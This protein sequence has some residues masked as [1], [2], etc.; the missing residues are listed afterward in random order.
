MSLCNHCFR[1]Q[2]VCGDSVAD[3]YFPG[4][5]ICLR[6]P[7][8]RE[9]VRHPIRWHI[10]QLHA[11]QRG[12]VNGPNRAPTVDY[13]VI[14]TPQTYSWKRNVDFTRS[15]ANRWAARRVWRVAFLKFGNAL[16]DCKSFV[17]QQQ[18]QI[19]NSK[20]QKNLLSKS[21]DVWVHE[22]MTHASWRLRPMPMTWFFVVPTPHFLSSWFLTEFCW[23]CALRSDPGSSVIL[24]A[25]V[26]F[27][28]RRARRY[29]KHGR[30]S[31][32]TFTLNVMSPERVWIRM[33]KTIMVQIH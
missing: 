24:A 2:Y 20:S 6:W 19:V 22:S 17:K 30:K 5:C 29:R 21:Q 28:G 9:E 32:P 27:G 14:F 23:Q 3:L 33:F 10:P 8:S 15:H 12:N 13:M 26:S 31:H 4:A 16:P 7:H 1:N 18:S 11:L 25:G